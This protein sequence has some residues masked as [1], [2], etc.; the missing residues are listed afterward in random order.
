MASASPYKVV[1]RDQA[2]KFLNFLARG[3]KKLGEQV[4]D[5]MIS[6]GSNPRPQGSQK[7]TGQ[8][9]YRVRVRD[10]RILYEIF[11]DVL[12]VT[13]VNIGDRKQVYGR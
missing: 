13:V 10:V 5:K 7:L 9:V 8:N 2:Q 4:Y 1:V 3:N 6:L 11:D 12:V